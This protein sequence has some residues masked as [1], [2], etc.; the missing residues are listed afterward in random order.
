[1]W[2]DKHRRQSQVDF[3]TGMGKEGMT[4]RRLFSNFSRWVGFSA[5]PRVGMTRGKADAA[6]L[7]EGTQ[8]FCFGCVK[9]D[10]PS[11]NTRRSDHPNRL[12]TK[13]EG[14]KW[15]GGLDSA[16]RRWER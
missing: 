14:L 2:T 6:G 9:L 12:G 5:V 15:Q 10:M 1:M 13:E 4:D 7:P 3:T 11:A 16:E 8:L